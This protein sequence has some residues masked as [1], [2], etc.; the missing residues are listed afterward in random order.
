MNNIL[1]LYLKQQQQQHLSSGWK[2]GANVNEGTRRRRYRS[3]CKFEY[4]YI[5]RDEEEWK[6]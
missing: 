1:D 3:L 4:G 5:G 6:K 2:A